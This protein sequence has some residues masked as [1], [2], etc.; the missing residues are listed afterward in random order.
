MGHALHTVYAIFNLIRKDEIL[1]AQLKAALMA[2]ENPVARIR[3]MNEWT[4]YA[5]E[6]GI[7]VT[8]ETSGIPDILGRL[9]DLLKSITDKL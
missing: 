6:N 2:T 3:L 8:E 1:A 7:P 4:E 9:K 5:K